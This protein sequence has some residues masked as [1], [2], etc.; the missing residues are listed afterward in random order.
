MEIAGSHAPETCADAIPPSR[1]TR[2]PRQALRFRDVSTRS[3]LDP[4]DLV[5]PLHHKALHGY[6]ARGNA[7]WRAVFPA[8]AEVIPQGMRG[9]KLR[10]ASPFHDADIVGCV[11]HCGFRRAQ[12]MCRED[13]L[14]RLRRH[15]MKH[16]HAAGQAHMRRLRQPEDVIAVEEH[17]EDI[18]AADDRDPARAQPCRNAGFL[19]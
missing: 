3:G 6:V 7:I 10:P 13:L 14:R 2:R 12:A 8:T 18:G 16:R 5:N 19:K 9:G 4:V 11:Q 17:V 15:M 1:L